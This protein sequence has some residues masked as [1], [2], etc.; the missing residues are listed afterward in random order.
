MR[1][2]LRCWR[3]MSPALQHRWLWLVPVGAVAALLDVAAGALLLKTAGGLAAGGAK[4]FG[5]SSA[6]ALALLG[7]LIL[8]KT[9][10]RLYETDR[11]ETCAEASATEF[12][13][14]LLRFWL[15]AP[16]RRQLSTP[17]ARRMDDIQFLAHEVGREGIH[18]LVLFWSEGL[19]V[20][21]LLALL[22]VAA[23]WPALA[24][25]ALCGG[26][27][28]LTLRLAHARHGRGVAA[29]APARVRV[30]SLVHDCI[31]GSREIRLHGRA[32]FFVRR[33]YERRAALGAVVVGLERWK[34]IPLLANETLFLFGAVALLAFSAGQGG[35]D[36]SSG[37]LLLLFQKGPV[38]ASAG[39]PRSRLAI[40]AAWFTYEGRDD[41]ALAGASLEVRPG[42]KLALVGPSGGGKSTLLLLLAA[43][44]APDRGEVEADGKPL[45]L[46]DPAW[47]DRLGFVA[48]GTPLLEA[49]VRANIA[50]GC[51]P[52]EI[53]EAALTEAAAIAQLGSV[54]A[55]L[56][57]GL[58]T[59][60]A[61]G[62]ELSGGQRQRVAL[63]RE[64][65]RRP[66]LLLLDEATAFV[67]QPVE[68]QI[69]A[70]LTRERPELTVVFVTHRLA[71]LGA[72]DRVAF[73]A[74]GRVEACGT[75]A[76][77]AGHA[78][79]QAFVAAA[80]HR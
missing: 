51:E 3:L 26:G 4:G 69:F 9:A 17:P 37:P 80:A 42:E 10:L 23:P 28:I 6:Q 19:V 24:V 50:L 27:A 13:Q 21:G 2:I 41:S 25:L 22:F 32:V 55:A 33:Y 52:D 76:E 65:Y 71:T 60:L 68:Q 40:T 67:D 70:A 66:S 58:E 11:R 35:S 39:G 53:D 56:P 59:V 48:Q 62:R 34:S 57:S 45:R 74:A 49:T 16:L 20:A 1:A 44:L 64:L 36:L 31:A 79:F 54:L 7:A 73:V 29:L 78:G 18:S 30:Q 15:D 63:A 8:V 47:Q 14:R 38:P 77:L 12:S 72:A 61:G 5:L 46:D 43:L 75:L